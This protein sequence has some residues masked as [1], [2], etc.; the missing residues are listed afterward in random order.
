MVH[1]EMLNGFSL[2][3]GDVCMDGAQTRSRK[4]WLLLAYLLLHRGRA[5]PQAELYDLLWSEE[6]GKDDPQNALPVHHHRQRTQLAK[7]DDRPYILRTREGYFW[8]PE[9]PAEVDVELFDLYCDQGDEAQDP[10]D[11]AE[12]YGKARDLYQTGFLT[13]FSGEHWVQTMELHYLN[14]YL[15]AVRICLTALTEEGSHEGVIDLAQNALKHEPFSEILWHHLLSSLLALGRRQE[16]ITA[17]EQARDLFLSDLGTMPAEPLRQLYYSAVKDIHD[18]RVPIDDLYENMLSKDAGKGALLCDYDFF[19]TVF[20]ATARSIGR[21]GISAQ[22]V[23]L[24]VE[25][26][27]NQPLPKRS[28]DTV[29]HGLAE[30]TCANL[31]RGD[32]V[33]LLSNN[34]YAILLQMANYENACMVCERVIRA[35]FRRYPHSPA[36]VHYSV[37]SI[38]PENDRRGAAQ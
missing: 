16:A 24:T 8:N 35:Y 20:Q 2:R 18:H 3:R 30:Q 9:I 37:K 29:M 38:E 33:T 32:V 36:D 22:L 14:R 34:Q 11:R 28:L 12:A 7:L 25:S 19:V 31:R 4:M 6:G 5:V 27:R 15:A 10:K 17:Y 1:I 21:S 23:V 13:K 26:H